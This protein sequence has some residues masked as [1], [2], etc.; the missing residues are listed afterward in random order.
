[1]ILNRRNQTSITYQQTRQLPLKCLQTRPTHWCTCALFSQVFTSLCWS[2]SFTDKTCLLFSSGIYQEHSGR[3]G[4]VA[5]SV[6]KLESFSRNQAQVASLKTR[7]HATHVPSIS[8]CHPPPCAPQ[9]VSS[10]PQT[11]QRAVSFHVE[12]YKG[13]AEILQEQC[14][15]DYFHLVVFNDILTPQ[16]RKPKFR[17]RVRNSRILY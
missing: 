2:T 5:C 4:Q 13:G 11:C 6:C 15:L 9:S 1:M 16:C 10:S 17:L 7:N 14:V 12:N 8:P 3:E